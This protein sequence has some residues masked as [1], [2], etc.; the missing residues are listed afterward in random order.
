M[1]FLKTQTNYQVTKS[2]LLAFWEPT[3]TGAPAAML[4]RL[5]EYKNIQYLN[6]YAKRKTLPLLI[7]F[8]KYFDTR[9]RSGGTSG[10]SVR[11]SSGC[12][13]VKI[14]ILTFRLPIKPASPSSNRLISDLILF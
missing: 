13:R 5:N 6:K 7:N 1:I 8:G 2:S 10:V 14:T 12:P 9:R 11:D 4:G 3:G